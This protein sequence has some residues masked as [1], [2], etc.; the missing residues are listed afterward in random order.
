MKKLLVFFMV[1]FGISLGAMADT[2]G[3]LKDSKGGDGPCAIKPGGGDV[4]GTYAIFFKTG[5]AEPTQECI[6]D[7]N[8]IKKELADL[9][10]KKDVEYF[11]VVGS[12]DSQGAASG[13]PNDVLSG[14]RYNYAITE[15]VPAYSEVRDEGWLAGDVTGR[16]FKKERIK[17]PL[18]RSVYIYVG[19]RLAQC[20]AKFVEKLS[21]YEKELTDALSKYPNDKN[22]IEN[23]LA[24]VKKAKGLC[25]PGKTLTA[26]EVEQLLNEVYGML[27]IA[28]DIVTSVQVINTEIGIDVSYQENSI[29]LQYSKLDSLRRGLGFSVW[30]DEEGKFN[31]ARL[32]S[33]SVAGVVLGTVGGIVTSKLVKKNQ[34]KKGFEDLYCAI[35]GQT[36]AEYGDDFTV[37]L[38]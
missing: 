35:G 16:L 11:V 14:N 33:D 30:R 19:W 10:E 38:R 25:A 34:L 32:I 29:D 22:K 2:L 21:A 37:G 23:A 6:N 27:I 8:K 26:S 5:E 24:G 28:G 18:Y 4:D 20:P 12:A 9:Y 17:N 15:I 31:T 7:F 36:V 3:T 1:L 13:Y